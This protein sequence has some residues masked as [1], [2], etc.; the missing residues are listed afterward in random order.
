[1]KRLIILYFTLFSFTLLAQESKK[2]NE[3]LNLYIDCEHC[4]RE[5]YRDEIAFVNHVRDRQDADVHLMILRDHTGSNG[6]LY[7]LQF[8][9]L[10]KYEGMSDTLTTSTTQYDTDDDRLIKIV[11]VIKAGLIRYISKTDNVDK[12]RI[13]F[14]SNG[15]TSEQNLI[16][17][18]D[19]WV[20]RA[21]LN[22]FF[23]GEESQNFYNLQGSFSA[24]RTT[25]DW[26]FQVS[27]KNSYNESNFEYENTTITDITR[28]QNIWIKAL[29]SIDEH[30]S[31]G[32]WL[33]VYSST[34]SNIDLSGT[35]A[36]GVEYNVFPYSDF[37]SKKFT[38]QYKISPRYN[39]YHE[40]TI[41]F[42]NDELLFEQ[43]FQAKLELKQPWGNID[44]QFDA[45]NYFH[46]LN[47]N[48]INLGSDFELQLIKGLSLNLSAGVS[49]VHDQITLP[50]RDASLDEV[51]LRRRELETQYYFYGHFGISYTFG[52]IY[53]NIVNPRFD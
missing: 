19:N 33:Y 51:L 13:S 52:S 29:M 5:Y 38:F 45:S 50:L 18:W 35:S 41:Y 17:E 10:K 31:A 21:R 8:F 20:F 53:N 16:D 28:S 37:S 11:R 47:K 24:N 7:T 32:T 43:E 49:R 15:K 26:V 42:K 30:W 44:I 1:M 6:T 27:L 40:Q 39:N 25:K 2:T 46:D 36:F 22:G 3:L 9:G 14:K 48:K 34:Y 12:L 23:N 4:D